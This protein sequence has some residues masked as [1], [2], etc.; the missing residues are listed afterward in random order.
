ML[1]LFAGELPLFCRLPPFVRSREAGFD[2]TG[3]S[4]NKVKFYANYF[5]LQ[6]KKNV[7]FRLYTVEF[8]PEIEHIPKRKALLRLKE[9][10]LSSYLFDGV[11]LFTTNELAPG[12]MK[13]EASFPEEPQNVWKIQISF[14]RLCDPLEPVVTQLYNVLM[15]KAQSMLNLTLLGR[16]YFDSTA[17]VKISNHRLELWPGYLTSM[18]QME[19]DVLLNVDLTWK[20]CRTEDI[21]SQIK[22]IRQQYPENFREECERQIVG[23]IVMTNYNKL[24]YKVNGIAW[25]KRP[26]D[27]FSITR[28]KVSTD[29]TFVEYYKKRGVQIQELAQPM[30]ISHATKRDIRRGDTGDRILVPETC[31]QTGLS[32]EMRANFRLMK[33]LGEHLHMAPQKRILKLVEFMKSMVENRDVSFSFSCFKQC[34]NFLLKI[35]SDN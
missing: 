10:E 5:L 16:S 18:R 33:D 32:D 1:S 9:P 29:I 24:T 6:T 30:L 11:Q 7:E 21:F 14:I 34:L 15:K 4:G 17:K 8:S 19:K 3:S 26:T 35:V 22:S 13:L 31:F 25:Q 20:V 27:T 23:T 2:K 28:K 12:V